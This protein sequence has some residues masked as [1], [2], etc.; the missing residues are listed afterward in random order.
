MLTSTR[1]LLTSTLGFLARSTAR[2]R[3]CCGTTT[4]RRSP[5][6]RLSWTC[7]TARTS[8]PSRSP[9]CCEMVEFGNSGVVGKGP[10]PETCDTISATSLLPSLV[11]IQNR[12]VSM[13]ITSSKAIHTKKNPPSERMNQFFSPTSRSTFSPTTPNIS[14]SSNF[15]QLPSIAVS[16]KASSMNSPVFLLASPLS[17]THPRRC[18]TA[19][20]PYGE[21]PPPARRI[22]NAQHRTLSPCGYRVARAYPLGGYSLF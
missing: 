6:I 15:A 13:Y 9:L 20:G 1:E 5:P 17:C 7:S 2:A 10:G 14:P 19:I 22:C 12:N 3:L 4:S 18:H 21:V 16:L 11:N 8:P